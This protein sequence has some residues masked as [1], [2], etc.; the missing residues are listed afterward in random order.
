M[1]YTATIDRKVKFRIEP[2]SGVALKYLR[3]Q[4]GQLL[5]AQYRCK[6]LTDVQSR[7]N[8]LAKMILGKVE[9]KETPEREETVT[10]IVN[11]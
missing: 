6:P 3:N 10:L 2:K 8:D 5:A 7:W 9:I 4:L 11:R 1:S